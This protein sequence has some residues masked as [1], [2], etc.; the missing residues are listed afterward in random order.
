MAIDIIHN[1]SV[2]CFH[3]YSCEKKAVK[4]ICLFYAMESRPAKPQAISLGK[5]RGTQ[6]ECRDKTR[7]AGDGGGDVDFR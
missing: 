6:N 1:A 4:H 5:L 2:R 3:Y 7:I